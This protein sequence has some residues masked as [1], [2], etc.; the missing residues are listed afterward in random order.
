MKRGKRAIKKEARQKTKEA[1]W[2]KEE[3]EEKNERRTSYEGEKM[4]EV[5]RE[6]EKK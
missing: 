1:K 2:R 4:G 5:D 3:T 6:R